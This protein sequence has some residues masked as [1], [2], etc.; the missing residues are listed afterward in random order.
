MKHCDSDLKKKIMYL[1]TVINNANFETSSTIF[2]QDLLKFSPHK[3]LLSKLKKELSKIRLDLKEIK[4]SIFF[5]NQILL[6][7][8]WIESGCF[9]EEKRL[10][11]YKNWRFI[12]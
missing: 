1:H 11:R 10:T 4:M 3:L 2:L 8:Q 6:L 12:D 5:P 9:S 7:Q